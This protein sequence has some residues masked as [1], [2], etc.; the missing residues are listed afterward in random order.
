M[1]LTRHVQVPRGSSAPQGS[2]TASHLP[3][4]TLVPLPV[5]F[6]YTW[7]PLLNTLN[8]YLQLVILLAIQTQVVQKYFHCTPHL[9]PRSPPESPIS[10]NPSTMLQNIQGQKLQDL[11]FF[12]FL[13]FWPS[14]AKFSTKFPQALSFFGLPWWLSGKESACHAGTTGEAAS[15]PGMG[16]S[17]GGGNGNKLQ[18]S[19][20][21]NSTD[22][23]ASSA[24]VHR[25]IKSQT[26]L[27]QLGTHIR[28][29]PSLHVNIIALDEFLS[30]AKPILP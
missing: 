17:L 21:E 15:I 29:C 28:V 20:L 22:R 10:A 13:I 19:C 25:V 3:T 5:P 1:L 6:V 16:R 27:K 12:P 26:R 8:I 9:H 2:L 11:G 4:Q 23:I 18:Y 30:W 24:T 7:L 14:V